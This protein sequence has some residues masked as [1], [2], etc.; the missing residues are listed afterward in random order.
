MA[1]PSFAVLQEVLDELYRKNGGQA[2]TAKQMAAATLLSVKEAQL[3]LDELQGESTCPE[4]KPKK[5]KKEKREKQPQ[6]T[7]S[8]A[9]SAKDPPPSQAVD[10]EAALS[11]VPPGAF[12]EADSD[13]ELAYGAAGNAAQDEVGETQCDESDGAGTPPY[14]PSL[15]SSKL[16]RAKYHSQLYLVELWCFVCGVLA[17]RFKS[18]LFFPRSTSTLLRGQAM[19]RGGSGVQIVNTDEDMLALQND[20]HGSYIH[21]CMHACM[22]MYS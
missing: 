18:N 12:E 2:P 17:H 5:A 3:I 7:E 19:L 16:R 4:P 21:A 15:T 14:S 1:D 9:S 10:K 22:T 13:E 6:K 20:M 11:A 8:T